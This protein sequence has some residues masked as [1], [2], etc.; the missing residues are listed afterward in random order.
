[1]T[2]RALGRSNSIALLLVLT[3]CIASYAFVLLGR[4]PSSVAL[5]CTHVPFTR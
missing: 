1:M 4:L 3:A 5:T 2:Q